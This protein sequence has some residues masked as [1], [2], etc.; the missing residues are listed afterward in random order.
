[1]LLIF[2]EPEG[3]ATQIFVDYNTKFRLHWHKFVIGMYVLPNGQLHVTPTVVA[4]LG[5]YTHEAAMHTDI[6]VG[7]YK[8][9]FANGQAQELF[10]LKY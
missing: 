10:V 4:I 3:H 9:E 2:V 5:H 6:Q 8:Y 7:E 1:V